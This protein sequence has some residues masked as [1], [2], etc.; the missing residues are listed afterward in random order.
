MTVNDF[1]KRVQD[2]WKTMHDEREKSADAGGRYENF[3]AGFWMAWGVLLAALL[4]AIR[5]AE[6]K[7][8]ASFMRRLIPLLDAAQRSI[9]IHRQ[10]KGDSLNT[11]ESHFVKFLL[12]LDNGIACALR[13]L[14]SM[15]QPPK[16]ESPRTMMKSMNGPNDPPEKYINAIQTVW[17]E[18]PRGTL[19][20]IL[21]GTA[22]DPDPAQHPEVL[23]WHATQGEFPEG[24]DDSL[25]VSEV[26]FA[27][28][29]QERRRQALEQFGEPVQPA[30]S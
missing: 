18:I 16:I 14:A 21:G 7:R 11:A 24:W 29:T 28:R 12:S 2:C 15:P 25:L 4:A 23:A 30:L 26:R 19:I 13:G 5:Y 3:T 17:Q 8:D 10:I 6:Q 22:D 1:I 9:T 27:E 20:A